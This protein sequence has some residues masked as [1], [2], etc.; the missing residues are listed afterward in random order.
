[1]YIFVV[2]FIL[3]FERD[4]NYDRS[5]KRH[6][7]QGEKFEKTKFATPSSGKRQRRIIYEQRF[8]R[9]PRSG[10]GKI[11]NDSPGMQR[12]MVGCSGCRH[13][14]IFT[15][16]FL[17]SQ[18]S[19]RKNW[20]ARPATLTPRTQESPQA[21]AGYSSV[22]QKISGRQNC[23]KLEATIKYDRTKVRNIDSS[24]NYRTCYC[25]HEKKTQVDNISSQR[26]LLVTAGDELKKSYEK[27]RGRVLGTS[28]FNNR[29]LG[30]ALLIRQGMATWMQ[31]YSACISQQKYNIAHQPAIQI[32]SSTNIPV[33]NQMVSIL[34]NMVIHSNAKEISYGC[35]NE[36]KSKT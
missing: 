28:V 19:F 10:T 2:T 3:F 14:R 23:V 29:V 12:R 31:K 33:A 13:I 1:V 15:R 24:S 25:T 30:L 6:G 18:S 11:R 35:T 27:L 5:Q 8:F 26:Q 21:I 36:S 9:L 32:S 22:Y 20:T 4:F 16:S 34:T 17:S 7:F